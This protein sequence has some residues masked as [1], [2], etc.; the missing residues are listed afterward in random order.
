[1]SRRGMSGEAEPF[2]HL[3][4]TVLAILFEVYQPFDDRAQEG[5]LLG[6]RLVCREGLHDGNATPPAGQ[7]D[8]ATRLANPSDD[9]PRVDLEGAGTRSTPKKPPVAISAKRF[10]DSLAKSSG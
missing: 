10:D 4:Q 6:L 3:G 7:Q 8:G 1:M 5:A 9:P 2:L